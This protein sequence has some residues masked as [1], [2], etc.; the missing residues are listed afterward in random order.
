MNI[1]LIIAL[2]VV[3]LQIGAKTLLKGAVEGVKKTVDYCRE[4]KGD[5]K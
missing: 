1:I 4:H 2:V 3:L 5:K